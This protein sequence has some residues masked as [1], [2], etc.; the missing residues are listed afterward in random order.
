MLAVRQPAP[1]Q[2]A[3]FLRYRFDDAAQ[4]RRH[5][6]LVGARAL[7]FY[8]LA[9]LPLVE[10]AR[11]ALEVSFATSDQLFVLHGQVHGTGQ[12]AHGT[13]L[14]F[15]VQRALTGLRE[16]ASA[17]KRRYRRVATDYLVNLTGPLGTVQLGRLLD[18]SPGGA[19]IGGVTGVT[20]GAQMRVR[21]LG[22]TRGVPSELGPSIV[23]WAKTGECAVKFEPDSFARANLARLVQHMHGVW[24]S[25]TTVVHPAVCH[26]VSASDV[27][28]PL[29]PEAIEQAR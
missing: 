2:S 21:V 10:G 8:P 18:V 7:L 29:T 9:H 22:A 24:E 26:C 23:C 27:F 13:W 1:Q 15:S 17:P 19:R 12:P 20:A 3:R 5:F 4:L 16:V 14:E 11:A 28:E 25:A 6:Q